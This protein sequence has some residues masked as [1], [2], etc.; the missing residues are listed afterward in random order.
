MQTRMRLN[1]RNWGGLREGAGR[2][3]RH[4]PGV[5]H[6]IREKVGTRTPLHVNFKY[7]FPVRN[8]TTLKLLKRAIQN[9]RTH[10]LKI[11]HYSFQH[12]HV[13][14]IIHAEDNSILTKGMRSLTITF[15]KGIKQGRIQLERYHLH[16]LKTAKEVKHTLHYVLFNQQKHE[17]GTCSTVDDYSSILSMER[18]LELIRKFASKKRMTIK[19]R[20]G[21]AWMAD[22][23]N[24]YL[25]QKG[26]QG[27]FGQDVPHNTLIKPAPR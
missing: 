6:S 24:S 7:R 26:L 16:V 17:N 3:R 23:C 9:A 4:S 18:G 5:A 13:H 14:L 10:G 25:Y 2:K 11:L 21:E 20:R 12:N 22:S 1:G 27:L 8:K 15:A 19:I